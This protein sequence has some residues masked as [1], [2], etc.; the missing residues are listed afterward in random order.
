VSDSP[1]NAKRLLAVLVAYEP[2]LGH[3]ESTLLR[4]ADA[5]DITVVDNS[6]TTQSRLQVA[7]LC[8]TAGVNLAT[9]G[10]N[11]GIAAAQNLGIDHARSLGYENVM[12]LD[13]DSSIEATTVDRLVTA[14]NAVRAADP[15]VVAVGPRIVDTRSQQTL[16]FAWIRNHIGLASMPAD[17]VTPVDVAFLVSSGSVVALS[18]FDQHGSFRSDYFIDQVDK[19]WGLRVGAVGKRMLVL[20]GEVLTH[21]LGDDASITRGGSKITYSHDSPTRHYYLTRNAI[22]LLRD[23]RLPLPRRLHLV[24]LLVD[25]SVR[26]I[27]SRRATPGRRR[28]V[29]RG[30]RDGIRN[31]RGPMS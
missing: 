17:G 20:P 13:D 24:R 12:F 19:E 18:A 14:L 26:K 29:L 25:S 8:D 3:L 5:V 23:T 30:W 21:R 10:Y 22:L 1:N 9:L 7:N 27:L 31:I 2:D 28:A 4:L 11:A 6:E 15:S 16:A